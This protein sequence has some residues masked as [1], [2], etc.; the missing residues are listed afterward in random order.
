MSIS[1][2]GYVGLMWSVLAASTLTQ[3]IGI[4]VGVVV[5]LVSLSTLMIRFESVVEKIV[6]NVINKM[7]AEGDL[8][9]NLEREE[10][11]KAVVTLVEYNKAEGS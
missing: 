5:I 6:R 7:Q 2:A 9:T 10:I 4:A 3:N 8:P 11:L 1:Y